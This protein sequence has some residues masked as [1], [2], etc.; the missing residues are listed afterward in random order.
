MS[1][2]IGRSREII[3]KVFDDYYF[4]N[5]LPAAHGGFSGSKMVQLLASLSEVYRLIQQ[6]MAIEKVWYD[7]DKVTYYTPVLH[8]LMQ[9]PRFSDDT[10][11]EYL[12]RIA[13]F[14]A[15]QQFGGQSE[16]SI[17]TVLVGLMS[18]AIT[19][20]N[21]SFLVPSD[22]ADQWD[23][24]DK[25]SGGAQWQDS[26]TVLDV[27]FLVR[28]DFPRAGFITDEYSWE[29]WNLEVNLTKIDDFVKLFKPLGNK[30]KLELNPP[31]GDTAGSFLKEQHFA[32]ATRIKST[33]ENSQLSNTPIKRFA[34][35][36]KSQASDTRIKRLGFFKSDFDF[37]TTL[38]ITSVTNIED[39]GND[40]FTAVKTVAS[41]TTI[42]A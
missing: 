13:Y 29:F 5:L 36:D 16:E 12:A 2:N 24:G 26:E 41:E 30:F 18:Q 28:I 42:I 11:V 40:K 17:R 3:N 33:E 14:D 15:A 7:D 4:N 25:W 31:P 27:D 10:D 38:N 20:S 6:Q 34:Y 9:I 35:D 1:S 37:D 8:Q 32:S 23:T 22:T 21:I 39:L 19:G